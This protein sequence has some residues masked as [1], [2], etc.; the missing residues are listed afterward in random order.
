VAGNQV[1]DRIAAVVNDEVIT[2]S[3]L[4]IVISFGLYDDEIPSPQD[5]NFVI[6]ERL[7]NQKL[8]LG[9]TGETV[10]VEQEE[11]AAAYGLLEKSL[12]SEGVENRLIEFGLEKE[13]LLEY[14]YEK[15]L[16]QKILFERFAM[17]AVVSLK[18]IE[19]FYRNKYVPSQEFKGL[20]IKPMVDILD[21]IESAIKKEKM[22]RRVE[23]WITHLKQEADIQILLKR[24]DNESHGFFI[25][26]TGFAKS[27]HGKGL[28]P[29]LITGERVF[30]AG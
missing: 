18:E 20:D 8:V 16:Y 25:P 13:A 1:V 23:E 3:D 26:W 21:E 29:I 6:L 15:I 30:C 27:R 22:S 10:P 4:R 5:K 7:I 11:I 17:A 14:L 24:R 12:G 28:C 19:D 2:L 9:L